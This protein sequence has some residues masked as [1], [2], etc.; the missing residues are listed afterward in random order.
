MTARRRS[1]TDPW[2]PIGAEDWRSGEMSGADMVPKASA[3]R[4]S[5]KWRAIQ[6]KIG[7]SY[8][9]EIPI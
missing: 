6:D 2:S 5:V 8:I 3:A 4:C 9:I 7:N 1:L